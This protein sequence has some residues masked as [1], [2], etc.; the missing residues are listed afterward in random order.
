MTDRQVVI[1][2]DRTDNGGMTPMCKPAD[3]GETKKMFPMFRG[4]HLFRGK[5]ENIVGQ[6]ESLRLSLIKN[7]YNGM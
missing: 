6:P 3:A 4:S 5:N 7:F 1:W 2:T